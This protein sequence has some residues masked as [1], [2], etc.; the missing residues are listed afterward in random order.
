MSG[1]ITSQEIRNRL[2]CIL[3]MEKGDMPT[4]RSCS[5]LSCLIAHIF[6]I[7]IC[8]CLAEWLSTYIIS[9]LIDIA[10]KSS[11]QLFIKGRRKKRKKK[12][13]SNDDATAQQKGTAYFIWSQTQRKAPFGHIILGKC[14]SKEEEDVRNGGLLLLILSR[15]RGMPY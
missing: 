6:M 14:N 11:L 13:F 1:S 5:L 9:L 4:S 12:V 15:G 10:L 7:S 3:E 8:K 2:P